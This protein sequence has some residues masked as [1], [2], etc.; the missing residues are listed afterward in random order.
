MADEQTERDGAAWYYDAVTTVSRTFALTIDELREPMAR[1]I[2]LGYL[3]CRIADTVEDARHI[4]PADRVALL[5]TYSRALDPDDETS[6]EA[7]RTAVEPWIPEEPSDDWDVVARAPEAVA[8]FDA[9][10]PAARE[11]I[12][13]SI[14]ELVDGMATF[15]ER[16]A[17]AG[18]L[19]LQ[20]FE[21]LEAYCW[22][23]A[24]TV[25]EFVTKLLVEDVEPA[26]RDSFRD[27]AESFALLLQLVNV[28][29]DVATDYR[30][31]RN[32]Y[33]P[34]D[35]LA[36][37][38]LEPADIADA[39]SGPAF[40]PVITQIVERAEQYLD[41]AQS[42][43]ETMPEVRGNTRSAWA[44]P[45]LLAVGTIR[46]LKA[47]PEAVIEEGGVTVSRREVLAVRARFARGSEPD[48]EALRREIRQAPLGDG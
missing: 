2:C 9:L 8:E 24:G 21:E 16:Y 28:A 4:P 38:G 20:S 48:I 5:E 35:L 18:G 43:L 36:D 30:T 11:V 33:A 14:R 47:N 27:D 17:D 23:V 42:W 39:S 1:E 19:R 22:Y 32:V 26:Q 10:P 25:G 44:I 37:E 12:R 45:F 34:Q 15:V 41:G 13:P 3:L 7:F 40:A 46:E 31:E 6:V 29:K